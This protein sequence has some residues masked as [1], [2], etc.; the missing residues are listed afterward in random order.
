MPFCGF[1]LPNPVESQS[2]RIRLNFT[3]DSTVSGKGFRLR[4]EAICGQIV[5]RNNHGVFVPFHFSLPHSFLPISIIFCISELLAQL[6]SCSLVWSLDHAE[7]ESNLDFF[8]YVEPKSNRSQGIPRP[9]EN[10]SPNPRLSA[11]ASPLRRLPPPLSVLTLNFKPY[12]L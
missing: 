10:L 11:P 9:R 7:N 4:W 3:A 8:K 6:L 1:E 5:Y 2:T 12:K